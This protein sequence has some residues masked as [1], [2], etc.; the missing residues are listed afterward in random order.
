MSRKLVLIVV[1]GVLLSCVAAL[2]LLALVGY[3]DPVFQWAQRTYVPDV[4]A[5]GL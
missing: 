4:S 2:A 3:A 1:G 5:A